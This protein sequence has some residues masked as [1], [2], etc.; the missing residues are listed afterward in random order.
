VLRYKSAGLQPIQFTPQDAKLRTQ[1]A[2][3]RLVAEGVVRLPHAHDHPFHLVEKALDDGFTIFLVRGRGEVDRKLTAQSQ[4]VPGLTARS[5]RRLE[6]S[7]RPLPAKS[8]V[9]SG[10]SCA[11]RDR[12]EARQNL[13]FV[14]NEAL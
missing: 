8:R 1:V 12:A 9:R 6:D 2:H 5:P 13:I 7:D 11:A 14:N 4:R 3:E 10:R